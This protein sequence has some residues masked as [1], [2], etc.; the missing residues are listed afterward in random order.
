MP[1][2]G[3]AMV[4]NLVQSCCLPVVGANLVS[5][6]LLIVCVLCWPIDG[7]VPGLICLLDA[8]MSSSLLL[9]GVL[10]YV[11]DDRWLAFWVLLVILSPSSDFQ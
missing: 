11:R 5:L 1:V 4:W 6:N 9:P 10:P 3:A 8:A 7:V 2:Y